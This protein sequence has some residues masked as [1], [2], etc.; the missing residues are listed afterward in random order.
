MQTNIH[1]YTSKLERTYCW[2]PQCFVKH[3][4]PRNFQPFEKYRK[5]EV[6][7]LYLMHQQRMRK[8]STPQ[9]RTTKAICTIP[10]WLVRKIWRIIIQVIMR[11]T[12]FPI[13]YTAPF[14]RA[15][16]GMSKSCAIVHRS[17]KPSQLVGQLVLATTS[18]IDRIDLRIHI[19]CW[20]LSSRISAVSGLL[21]L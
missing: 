15:N 12:L 16:T 21:R 18:H 13:E 7:L 8:I 19:Y 9:H 17:S 10:S 2:T 20:Q 1:N 3:R 5:P 11:F 4:M 14:W 6:I